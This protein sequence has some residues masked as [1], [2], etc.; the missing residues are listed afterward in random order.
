MDA[1]VSLHRS[2]GIGLTIAEAISVGVPVVATDYGGNVDFLD[3]RCGY[4]VPFAMIAN[5]KQHGP[6]PA[7]ARWA[8]PSVSAAADALR[9]MYRD[10]EYHQRCVAG[11]SA[12]WR[13]KL[14]PDR[15][16][17]AMIDRLS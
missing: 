12:V 13:E 11:C 4:P 16:A 1:Y 3:A 10:R 2:E 5:D 8:E 14:S 6:Y 17:S 15:A 7:G 9:R